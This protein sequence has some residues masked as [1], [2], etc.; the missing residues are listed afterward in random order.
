M[1]TSRRRQRAIG[2]AAASVATILVLA[3]RPTGLAQPELPELSQD[4]MR[5]I[6]DQ[7]A[8][9]A[10]DAVAP[11]DEVVAECMR[12]KGQEYVVDTS[13]AF[14]GPAAGYGIVA[15]DELV[16]ADD[17]NLQIVERLSPEQLVTYEVALYGST[18]EE[19]A[20]GGEVGGCAA[21]AA[22]VLEQVVADMLKVEAALARLDA[23]VRA[24]ARYVAAEEDWASCMAERTGRAVAT[25]ED[26]P[27]LI[28]AA[29]AAAGADE[30]ALASVAEEEQALAAADA[31]CRAET[32]EPVLEPI[33]VERV[34]EL[35]AVRDQLFELGGN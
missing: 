7:S 16:R 13:P 27:Q 31:A 33:L 11:V 5:V 14:A 18:L 22:P 19:L 12:R 3:P 21:E 1:R 2:L 26:P 32:V 25:L 35:E 9:L 28:A 23:E 34:A 20:D 6:D 30:D 8:A 10:Q 4:V 17:P 29:A 24:D 15:S